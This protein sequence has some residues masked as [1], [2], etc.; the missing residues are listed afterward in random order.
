[1]NNSVDKSQA[2][3]APSTHELAMGLGLFTLSVTIYTVYCM[4]IKMMMGAFQL[5]VPEITYYVSLHLVII[6][7][8]FARQQ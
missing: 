2:A 4:L 5:T 3:A 6:F 7:Y 1:M 8:F